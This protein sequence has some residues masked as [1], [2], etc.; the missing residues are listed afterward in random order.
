M[1]FPVGTE[2]SYL[3]R[4]GVPTRSACEPEPAPDP[5]N[6]PPRSRLF[7]VVPKTADGQAIE[8]NFIS[9][10]GCS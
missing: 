9:L 1:R 10:Q 8:V 3:Y 7:I 5:D 2:P 6:I 4:R